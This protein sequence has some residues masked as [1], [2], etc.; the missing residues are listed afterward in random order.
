VPYG[1]F[2]STVRSLRLMLADGT[3][4][5]CS[6]TENQELFRLAM[7][8]YGLVGI[9]VE[10]EGYMVENLLLRPT[11][12][13]MPS[14]ELAGRFIRAID[15]DPL[16]R[17]AYGRLSVARRGFLDEALLVTYRRT[18]STGPLPRAGTGGLVATV[19]REVYR[20]QIGSEAA[21]RA[22]WFAET[23]AMPRAAS[24]IATRNTL[25]NEPVSNLAGRDRSRTDILHEYFV[26]P[27]RFKDFVAACQQIIPRSGIEFLNVTLRYVAADTESVLSF[28]PTRRIAAV[29]SF[30]QEL[31]PESEAKMRGMTEALIERVV[32]IGGAFYL[33]YRLHAKREQ[34][35][36]AYA[37]VARFVERKRHYDPQLVFR[38]AMWDAYFA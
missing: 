23:R 35:E 5:S 3:V 31:R 13:V 27:D 21:K 11:H 15:D 8:G 33:P 10:L 24:G 34:V 29:M 16:V 1:P 25:M 38:N 19:S 20:A 28:A 32:A 4:V 30:S 2:G 22:R 14:A 9:V 36:K 26:P 6:R 17:M 37:N 7:G 18:R 12:A